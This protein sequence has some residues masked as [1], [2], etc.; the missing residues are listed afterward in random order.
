MLKSNP[1]WDLDRDASVVP[2]SF[3]LT[4]FVLERRNHLSVSVR[5]SGSQNRIWAFSNA[6]TCLLSSDISLQ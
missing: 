6:A 4:C 3:L 1:L 2:F 5:I